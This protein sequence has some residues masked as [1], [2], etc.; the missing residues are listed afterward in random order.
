MTSYHGDIP[1]LNKVSIKRKFTEFEVEF[2]N[3]NCQKIKA[4]CSSQPYQSKPLK[5]FMA[6][7]IPYPD[8]SLRK[9]E[10][11]QHVVNFIVKSNQ[12]LS[13]VEDKWFVA[14]LSGFDS[15]LKL[16][17]RQTVMNKLVP[18]LYESKMELLKSSI[19]KV[20]HCSLTCDRWTSSS[21]TSYLG[22]TV[23]FVEDF[24][25]KSYLL[26]LRQFENSYTA[27]LEDVMEKWNISKKVV[28]LTA[29]DATNFKMVIL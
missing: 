8:D 19:E 3:S 15:K 17:C 1:L 5:T 12:P 27:D 11:V 16:P 18:D 25:L 20:K 26:T 23:H 2:T 14:M 21:S 7:K 9:A 24:V 6:S 10:L 4:S 28:N 13:L 29:H 22:V